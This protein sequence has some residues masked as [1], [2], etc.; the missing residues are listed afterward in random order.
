MTK[1]LII[2]FLI[3]PSITYA[4]SGGTDSNGCHHD[5]KNGGYHCHYKKLDMTV[6]NNVKKTSKKKKRK[7]K[8]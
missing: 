1:I 6:I 3:L 5:R 4:H 8:I 7:D 2:I